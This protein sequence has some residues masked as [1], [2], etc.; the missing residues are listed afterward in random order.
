[1]S[2]LDFMAN[3]PAFSLSELLVAHQVIEHFIECES[4]H[5]MRTMP[6]EDW[7]RLGQLRDYLKVMLG[8][9]GVEDPTAVDYWKSLTGG[10][11]GV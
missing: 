2:L 4:P 11:D 5:E 8:L 9:P 3:R 1:M 10:K 6:A 7:N